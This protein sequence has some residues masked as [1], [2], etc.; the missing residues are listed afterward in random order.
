[1]LASMVALSL[2]FRVK[3]EQTATG[4]SAAGDQAWAAAMSGVEE[5]VRVAR[6]AE[7]ET[8]A[9]DGEENPRAFQDRLFYDD[10]T[11]RWFFSIY[12]PALDETATEP[13]FGLTDEAGKLNIN[14][15]H[16]AEVEKLPGLTTALA[17]AARDYI[18]FDN[19]E[20]PDG[21]EQ[22]YYSALARPYEIRNGPL[23]TLDE[24]LLVRGFTPRLLYGEDANMNCRL[25]LNED[26]GEERPPSDN[27]D[28]RL[29]LGLRRY[30][31]VS[32][33]EFDNDH[34]GAPRTNLNNPGD[35]LPGVELPAA[36]T[37]FI[38]AFR[39]AKGRVG[40]V[41][42]L[43]EA[44]FKFKDAAGREVAMPSGVGPEELPLLL[45]LFCAT[46]DAEVKGL[47]NIN[48]AP[49]AVLQT[50]PGIDEPLADAIL[51]ARKSLSFERR[52]S[53]AWLYQE[54][55]VDAARFKQLAPFLTAR[56]YQYSFRALGYGLC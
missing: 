8:A 11:E 44:T 26:D 17:Q 13:R 18:D 20:R 52:R 25:D 43:L 10:G 29:D 9:D 23:D 39:Q 12:S 31:T 33:Y 35:P 55:L 22:E 1:M 2:L 4:A 32:S 15:A 3:A 54:K 56:G 42:D 53:I 48:T 47:V 6:T 46:D 14:H 40:H 5:A 21:A 38:A 16:Q 36:L 19:A 50:V 24:L 45:D 28:G 49:A 41:A 51:A 7:S 37:N 30:L 27:R 34:D